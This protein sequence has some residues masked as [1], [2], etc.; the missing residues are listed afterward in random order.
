MRP[1]TFQECEAHL[2]KVWGKDFDARHDDFRAAMAAN[3]RARALLERYPDTLGNKRPPDR[4]RGRS[5]SQAPRPEITIL[6][7]SRSEVS[8][9][10][11]HKASV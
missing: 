9:R 10:K 2:H 1:M 5:L 3:Q 11:G 4:A 7:G 8:S 6:L